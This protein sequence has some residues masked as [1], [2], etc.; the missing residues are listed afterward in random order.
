MLRNISALGRAVRGVRQSSSVARG[1]G[2]FAPRI[3]RLS[4]LRR[5]DVLPLLSPPSALTLPAFN[6]I[7]EFN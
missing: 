1:S 2:P 3:F 5:A 4:S 7:R 6:L